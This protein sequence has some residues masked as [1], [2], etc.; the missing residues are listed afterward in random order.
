MRRKNDFFEITVMIFV[1]LFAIVNST[2]SAQDN[3]SPGQSAQVKIQFIDR[4]GDGINDMVQYSWGLTIKVRYTDNQ[5]RKRGLGINKRSNGAR[6]PYPDGEGLVNI[7][8]T[9]VIASTIIKTEFSSIGAVMSN[10][11]NEYLHEQYQS[12]DRNGDGI[13]DVTALADIQK[14]MYEMHIWRALIKENIRQGLAPYTDENGDRIP[15]HMPPHLSGP[16]KKGSVSDEY[17][18]M[19]KK[20]GSS[21]PVPGLIHRSGSNI[22]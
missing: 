1:I 8:F 11:L 3:T 20:F 12:F 9:D 2:L 13:P 18:N 5:T 14:Y 4:D 22:K 17:F 10:S 16:I 15:D 19:P 7:P 21:L 6:I